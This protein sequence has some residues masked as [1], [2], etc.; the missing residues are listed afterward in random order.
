MKVLNMKSLLLSLCLL[1]SIPL[2]AIEID[3]SQVDSN[4][5]FAVQSSDKNLSIQWDSPE[6]KAFMELQFIP[7]NGGRPAA[8]LIRAIGV[9]TVAALEGLDPNYLFWVG[10]RDLEKRSGWSIFFDRVPTRPYTVEKGYLIPQNVHVSTS[11]GRATIELDGLSSERFSG[12]LAFTFYHGSPFVHME[13]RVSTERE[14]TAFL[15]HVGLAKP[16][17]EGHQLHWVDALGKPM[18]A[19]TKDETA[20][21]YKTRYRS[22]ALASKT[23]SVAI[24]PFPHQ[25][26]YPLDFAENY[27]YNWAGD[28]YLDMIDGFAWGVRQ[29]PMGDRRY[30]PWVNAPSGTQQKLGV[31]L[32]VSNQSG[33]E[34]LETV[35]CYTRSD[36]FKPLPGYKT[37]TSHYHVEHSLDYIAK[38]EEQNTTGI[39]DGLE[40]PEFVNVFK[41]M[42]VDI[43]HLGEFH[44]GA[45]RTMPTMERLKQL[46]VMHDECERLSQDG[47]LL[48]PGEEPNVHLGGHWISFFPKPI[49]WVL[50]RPEDEPFAQ[51]IDGYGT[52]YHVGSPEDV[53]ELLKRENGL[54]WTA[55]ARV[56]GSTGFPDAYKETPLFKSDR[57]LGA[58]WKA[59][60]ADYSRKDLGWRVSELLDD[61]SN[62]GHRKYMLGEV[63]IFKIFEDYE[64]FGAMN[65]NYLKLDSVPEYQDG[66]Q[67]VLDALSQGQFFL[68][69]GEILIQEFSINGKE[70]GEAL[71][72]S[73]KLAKARLKADI[74]WTYP[75]SRMVIVSG[76]RKTIYRD[77]IDMTDTQEFGERGLDLNVDLSDRSWVRLEIWDIA[78]NG[79]FTQPI[80]IESSLN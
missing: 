48:L 32:F 78:N 68:T 37:F 53:H 25:Y 71:K 38:Q 57:F 75:L 11:G 18:T 79:A 59:M 70:S 24:S 66:W 58:A 45:T 52:V 69:T 77:R 49:N 1:L 46:K 76:D 65:V 21:V 9:D 41:N 54:A 74:E 61:I 35:Q 43:V 2:L 7:R 8:P 67:P 17:T 36:S 80:W 23:G 42:G 13:A 5:G 15:Y 19:A 28:E 14:A 60:P 22:M 73:S 29:P 3:Q 47:F 20:R 44:K 10:E 33:A 26:L 34:N 50:I 16:K 6:G 30:V 40:K 55:H 72:R 39:P 31:L 62:W 27:G 63:D 12:S 56:K 64:L 51:E 4:D